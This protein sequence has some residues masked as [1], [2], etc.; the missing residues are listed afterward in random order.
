MYFSLFIHHQRVK[1]HTKLPRYNPVFTIVAKANLERWV[2]W[3]R[4]LCRVGSVASLSNLRHP[5]WS[6]YSS[7]VTSCRPL[8]PRGISGYRS[9]FLPCTSTPRSAPDLP[10][11]ESRSRLMPEPS[12]PACLRSRACPASA[13][14]WTRILTLCHG[15]CTE[16]IHQT[17][18]QCYDPNYSPLM[19]W[20]L[21]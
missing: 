15:Y 13:P 16:I 20:S 8:S 9:A 6:L 1:A 14:L 21:K 10:R 12:A 17:A 11:M 3:W 5:S 2:W 18:A 7:T 19:T 4:L